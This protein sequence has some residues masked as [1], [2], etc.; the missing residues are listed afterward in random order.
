MKRQK[1]FLRVIS[2][3]LSAAIMLCALPLGMVITGH[4]ATPDAPTELS[5]LSGYLHASVTVTDNN[6][7]LTANVHTYYDAGKTTRSR[8]S[9]SPEHRLFC[10]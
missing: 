1:K 9:V 7:G 8:M 2:G 3:I 4:A 10:M 6:V 5:E